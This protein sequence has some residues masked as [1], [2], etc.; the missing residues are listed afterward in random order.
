MYDPYLANVK[1]ATSIYH[2]PRYKEARY[3]LGNAILASWMLVI[4]GLSNGLLPDDTK[5]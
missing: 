4:I 5:P 3:G 1:Y 2:S